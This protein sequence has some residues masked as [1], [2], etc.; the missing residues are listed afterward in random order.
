MKI[1]YLNNVPFLCF[2]ALLG[3]IYI[4]NA[5]SVEKKLRKIEVLKKEVKEEKWKY[6]EV[7]TDIIHEST[8]SQLAKKLNDKEIKINDE[9]PVK[10]NGE[11][12]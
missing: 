9:A 1:R 7:K 6:M 5:H 8:E 2:I 11:G 10:L 4:S 12:E 3:V